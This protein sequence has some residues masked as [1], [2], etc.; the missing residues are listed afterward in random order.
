MAV[1]IGHDEGHGV[2]ARRGKGVRDLRA[3]AKCSVG[4]GPIPH[5]DVR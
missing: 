4:E 5:F 2:D 3:V 1:L